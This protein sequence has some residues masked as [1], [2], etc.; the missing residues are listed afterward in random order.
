MDLI[1]HPHDP[2]LGDEEPVGDQ[3][4]EDSPVGHVDHRHRPQ[5]HVHMEDESSPTSDHSSPHPTSPL[6][7]K[8]HIPILNVTIPALRHEDRPFRLSTLIDKLPFNFGWIPANFTWSKIKPVIRCALTAWVS[9]IFVVISKT[10][11]VLGQVSRCLACE[12]ACTAA[13]SILDQNQFEFV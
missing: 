5:K 12:C 1:R 4:V 7:E 13:R 3:D 2:R 9:I 10:E 8:P 6:H 11:R